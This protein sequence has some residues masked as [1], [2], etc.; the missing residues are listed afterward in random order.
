MYIEISQKV[1][2]FIGLYACEIRDNYIFINERRRWRSSKEEK[3]QK[4]RTNQRWSWSLQQNPITKHVITYEKH[5]QNSLIS[6]TGKQ[7]NK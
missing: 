4:K 1:K 3:V 5:G 6:W 7:T 2:D